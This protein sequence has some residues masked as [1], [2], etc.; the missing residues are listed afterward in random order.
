MCEYISPVDSFSSDYFFPVDAVVTF[1]GETLDSNDEREGYNYEIK[2]CLRSISKNMPWIRRIYVLQGSDAK[3]PSFFSETYNKNDVILLSDDDIIPEKYL[4]TANSDSIETFLTSLPGLSEQF[5]YFCD[6]MF[7]NKLTPIDYFFTPGG[8][9][10]RLAFSRLYLE[11]SIEND[12]KAPPSPGTEYWYPH[13]PIAYTKKEINM[14]LEKYPKFI[15]YIRSIRSRKD[16]ELSAKQCMQ[17]GLTYPCMQLHTNVDLMNNGISN[18]KYETSESDY[19][20]FPVEIPKIKDISKRFFC[21]GDHFIGS[22]EERSK[23][24]NDLQKILNELFP[25]KS[26]A[27]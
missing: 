12:I 19:I 15:E 7:V 1:R 16:R 26:R 25:E 17:I 5:I 22:L 14:Y 9:P 18:N 6:D 20:H 21:V 24:R 8:I 23:Y 3:T 10:K 4:P 11:Q 13:V 2:Y 27:E